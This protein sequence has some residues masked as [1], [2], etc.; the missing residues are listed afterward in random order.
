MT[1]AGAILIAATP[2]HLTEWDC[3]ALMFLWCAIFGAAAAVTLHEN[4]KR[5]ER[6]RN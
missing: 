3:V 2:I 1:T 5:Q 6:E 4:A